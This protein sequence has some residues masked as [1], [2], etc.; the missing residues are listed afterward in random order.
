MLFAAAP[1]RLEVALERETVRLNI[2]MDKKLDEQATTKEFLVVR[3]EGKRQ[4]R[5]RI[6]HYNLDAI[7]SVRYRVSFKR[8]TRFPQRATQ[9]LKDHL[10]SGQLGGYSSRRLSPFSIRA[11]P[12][13][14]TSP[15]WQP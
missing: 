2:F 8:A 3:Q 11:R 9:V 6:R 14:N 15:E 12:M 1:A 10:V 5:R 4:V 13:A 7:I